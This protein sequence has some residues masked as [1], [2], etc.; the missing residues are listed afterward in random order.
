M[1]RA[2]FSALAILFSAGHAFAGGVYVIR[3]GWVSR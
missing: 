2:T 1:K 3:R